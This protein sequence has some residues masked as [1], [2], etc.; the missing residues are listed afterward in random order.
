MP[1]RQE[2]DREEVY[3]EVSP[4]VKDT[5]LSLGVTVISQ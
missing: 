4:L 5:L 3:L 2:R 1:E